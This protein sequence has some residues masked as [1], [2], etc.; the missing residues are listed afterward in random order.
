MD[1][2]LIPDLPVDCHIGV[3]EEER[4]RPQRLLISTTLGGNLSAAGRSDDFSATV[5]YASVAETITHTAMDRP[6]ALIETLAEDVAAE[7]L[8]GYS[9][10]SVTVKI[11]KPSA[12]ASK[13]APYAAVEIERRRR[14]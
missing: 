2:I 12:L 4:A 6:R 8:A 7:I 1:R 13:G 10:D 11:V 9:V 5:D 3:P 14:R